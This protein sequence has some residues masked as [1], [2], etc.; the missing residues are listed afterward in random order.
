MFLTDAA[1]LGLA[2]LEFGFTIIL[3][4]ADYQT[5]YIGSYRPKE[6][7]LDSRYGLCFR[8]CLGLISD[9]SIQSFKKS[10]LDIHFVLES[11][12][13]NWTDADRIFNRVKKSRIEH[14]Q[15]IVTA[16]RTLTTADKADFPGLQMAD[17][18]AYSAFQHMTRKALPT[19]K[20]DPITTDGYMAEAKKRQRV[21]ILHMLLGEAELKRFKQFVIDEI[22]E[23]RARR[24]S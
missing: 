3:R 11:G 19:A 5:H 8:Y 20:L 17:A 10:D 4:E 7:P 13:P 24:K 12:H 2:N 22:E 15:H 1:K 18:V 21:P 23:R 9:L 14:E 16:L 6:V